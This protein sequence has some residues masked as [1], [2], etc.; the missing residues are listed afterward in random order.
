M[1]NLLRSSHEKLVLV[2]AR[3]APRTNT[4][5]KKIILIMMNLSFFDFWIFKT[6]VHVSAR[7]TV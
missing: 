2:Q 7:T 5:R 4:V 3:K 1:F 6:S